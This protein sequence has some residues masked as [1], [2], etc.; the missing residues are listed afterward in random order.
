MHYK[1]IDELPTRIRYNLP[2]RVQKIFLKAYNSTYNEYRKS[3]KKCESE[4]FRRENAYKVAW[5]TVRELYDIDP[6]KIEDEK[7]E[8][9]S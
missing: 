6:I 9:I 8:V 2:K 1:K 7:K 3:S 5:S 4:S